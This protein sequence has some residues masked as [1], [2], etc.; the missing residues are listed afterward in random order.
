MSEIAIR[1]EGGQ[2][3]TRRAALLVAGVGVVAF[4]LMLVL[5]AY[6]PDLRSGKNGGAHALSNAATGFSGLVRH[7]NDK[8]EGS[9]REVS[10]LDAE[11]WCSRG[12][13]E[14]GTN[15]TLPSA[16][17]Y[18]DQPN[19]IPVIDEVFREH[20]ISALFIVGG[21]EAFTALSELRQARAQHPGLQIPMVSP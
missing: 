2:S 15:R 7:H 8:P 17:G 13:S 19:G 18:P 12:G 10:W 20:R 6:A 11:A 1:L 5:G 16:A 4:V 14:I 3:F 21:F 9:V